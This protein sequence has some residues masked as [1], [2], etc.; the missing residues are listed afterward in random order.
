MAIW[1]EYLKISYKNKFKIGVNKSTFVSV[2]VLGFS[3]EIE[4]TGNI[5][6]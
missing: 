4:S 1:R 6:M 5:Y 3:K 2:H